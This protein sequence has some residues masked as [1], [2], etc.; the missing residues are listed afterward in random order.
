MRWTFSSL[1]G[2]IEAMKA[3]TGF[4][5]LPRHKIADELESGLLKVLQVRAQ[6]RRQ[7]PVH[8]ITPEPE[9]MAPGARMLAD[10]FRQEAAAANWG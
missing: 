9:T 3:G 10:A 1:T 5:W 4:A 8:L 6:E 2:S 7:A